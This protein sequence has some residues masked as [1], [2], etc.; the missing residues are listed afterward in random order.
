M[1]GP[2][3]WDLAPSKMFLNHT[4]ALVFSLCNFR[5]TPLQLRC[6]D[7]V[8]VRVM[9]ALSAGGGPSRVRRE[10]AEIES[11]VQSNFDGE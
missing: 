8:D 5:H 9:E 2:N 7:K 4:L 1:R 11:V 6:I 10:V 3:H